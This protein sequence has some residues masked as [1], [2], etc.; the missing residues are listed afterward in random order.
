MTLNAF[1]FTANI[2]QLLQLH[3]F[4]ERRK[5]PE[6]IVMPSQ[7]VSGTYSTV[8]QNLQQSDSPCARS[9]LLAVSLCGSISFAP[10][11]TACYLGIVDRVNIVRAE[12]TEPVHR[13]MW[14]N[15]H[16][17]WHRRRLF[18]APVRPPIQCQRT[19]FSC[20]VLNRSIEWHHK[21]FPNFHETPEFQRT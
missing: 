20:S 8:G 21:C 1:E 6:L 9:S 11:T 2:F 16:H 17:W 5:W 12:R 3:H 4:Y 14:T 7:F 10:P 15:V 19:E 13:D 18:D